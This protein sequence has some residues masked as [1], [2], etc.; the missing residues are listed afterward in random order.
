MSSSKNMMISS[1]DSKQEALIGVLCWQ[2]IFGNA[3]VFRD[4]KENIP[5]ILYNDKK[6][7]ST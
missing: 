5:N 7:K 2:G 1:E 6:S 3:G 4:G